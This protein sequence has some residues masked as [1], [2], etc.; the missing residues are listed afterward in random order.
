MSCVLL[1]SDIDVVKENQYME[2]LLVFNYE[3][4]NENAWFL[5]A[6]PPKSS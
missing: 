4:K 6:I 5:S 1:D 3:N 2:N